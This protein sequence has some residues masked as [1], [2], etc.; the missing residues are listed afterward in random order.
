M[1]EPR[2]KVAVC[3]LMFTKERGVGVGE[4]RCAVS[5]NFHSVNSPTMADFK[6][7]APQEK[8]RRDGHTPGSPP[9]GLGQLR[10]TTEWRAPTPANV[11]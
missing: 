2:P 5:A 7:L 4:S 10:Y 3:W 9:G 6:L 11:F 8:L 1:A